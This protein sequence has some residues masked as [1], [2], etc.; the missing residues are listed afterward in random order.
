MGN[1]D[2]EVKEEEKKRSKRNMKTCRE[3]TG[4]KKLWIEMKHAG[5]EE[6]RVSYGN[7][8]LKP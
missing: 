1:D 2:E 6:S 3:K 5:I 7:N 8:A 4:E